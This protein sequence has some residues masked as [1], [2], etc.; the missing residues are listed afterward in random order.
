[1]RNKL[2]DFIIILLLISGITLIL[3]P[4]VSNYINSLRQSKAIAN[5]LESVDK[6]KAYNKKIIAKAQEY[7]KEIYRD[8]I[9]F[10][11]KS[12]KK[13][14]YDLL[15]FN[16]TDIMSIITI[17]KI[18][19]VLPIYHGTTEG[20]LQNGIGHLEG[21]SLP[22]GGNNTHTVLM[23]HR[24]LPSSKLFTSLDKLDKGDIIYLQTANLHLA[25]VVDSIKVVEPS[26]LNNLNILEGKDYLSLITCTPYGVNTHRLVIGA[27]RKELNKE[28][29]KTLKKYQKGKMMPFI[30]WVTVILL[31]LL[32]I[33][34][35][36]KK[37]NKFNRR[38]KL[39]L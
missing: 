26:E 8:N 28:Q 12:I 23:G 1:M 2:F 30:I 39:V 14:Y 33:I 19:L 7:N 6:N 31:I 13:D 16:N 34:I 24:G 35:F 3:Y 18:D 10:I 17:P 25:Y 36:Y 9:N 27:S 21:S 20:V 4:S 32:F 11:N 15:K 5:Y 29:L 37:K 38:R 22:I